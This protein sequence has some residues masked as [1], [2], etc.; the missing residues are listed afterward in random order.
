MQSVESSKLIRHSA[1]S[2]WPAVLTFIFLY[3]M[4]WSLTPILVRFNLP[5]DALEGVT[6]GQQLE[7]GYDKNPFM[8]AWL[9]A[10]AVHLN[11]SGLL[12]YFFSQLSVGVS[13]LSIWLLGKKILPPLYAFIAILLLA[14]TQYFN[15]HAIDFN[16]NTLEVG[17]WSLTILFFYNAL[18]EKKLSDWLLTGF[19]AGLSMMT[20]YFAVM[21]F[22]PMFIF[23]LGFKET[24]K[25]FKQIGFYAAL[26]VFLLV[27]TPHIFWLFSH[28][29]LTVH[30][31][32][33][34]VSSEP[35][36][37][38]HLFYPAQFAWQQLEVFLPAIALFLLLL[39]KNTSSEKYS[40]THYNKLFLLIVGLGPL[41]F[42][43][44]LS[45]VSGIK[46]RAG[47]GQPLLILWSLYLLAMVQPHVTRKRLKLFFTAFFVIFIGTAVIYAGALI[48]ASD[49]SS[50]NF[51][52][53]PIAEQLETQWET[54]Y[55]QPLSYIVGPRWLSGNV[56]FYSS[57]HPKVYING[58]HA[59]SPWIDEKKL[60]EKG[61]IF[62]WDPTEDF[63]M[64]KDEMKK[65]FPRLKELKIMHVAWMRNPKMAPVEFSVAYLPPT[66]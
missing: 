25:E 38:N 51:P 6:W 8:N 59:L 11:P 1:V 44:L 32:F 42:T 60:L 21:L 20:K 46:L 16:D 47:W 63:Q 22:V 26:V 41:F 2:L 37:W 19:F 35:S 15:L 39:G 34:R 62:V 40:V 43:I 28:D 33:N 49:P 18:R 52:G 58:D 14:S 65:R 50:A 13:F 5:L 12:I 48:Q 7:W 10:L 66:I 54:T 61:A 27:C 17:L 29:F 64:S 45:G 55:H 4:V 3:I 23:M 30:Y 57:A 9:T 56:A 36:P 31:A 53:K 24:R